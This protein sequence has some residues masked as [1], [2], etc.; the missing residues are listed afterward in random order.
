MAKKS[1]RKP[2]AALSKRGFGWLPD[3][4]D[5]R[6][7][8]YAAIAKPPAELPPSVDLRKSFSPVED[9]GA[10]NSCTANAIVGVLEFL[11]KKDKKPFVDL[12][13]LFVYYNERVI[14]HSVDADQ[15]AFI[16]DGIKSI[17]KQGVCTE[18]KWPYS[19]SKLYSKPPV[20]CYREA[21]DHQVTSYHRISSLAEMRQCL[22]E[23]YPFVFGFTVYTAFM[24]NEVKKSGVLNMPQLSEKV[25]GGHAVVAVGY[26][27]AQKRFVVRNSWGSGWGMKGYYTMPYDYLSDRNLSDDFWTVRQAENI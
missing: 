4:P 22:A 3:L 13:R 20:A 24:S 19:K 11:E 18:S 1:P 8:L 9:Q 23:G 15:G 14:E 7:R 27:D 17:V 26:D 16:R 12:S 21:A 5:Q 2:N 10:M 25:E 6:D